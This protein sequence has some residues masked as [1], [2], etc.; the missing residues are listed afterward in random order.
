MGLRNLLSQQ[1]SGGNTLL[2]PGHFVYE[3]G[4]ML[5]E[6]ELSDNT[7][8]SWLCTAHIWAWKAVDS[9]LYLKPKVIFGAEPIETDFT[10]PAV[11]ERLSF[12]YIPQDVFTITSATIALFIRFLSAPP[13]PP[14][15]ATYP[16]TTELPLFTLRRDHAIETL[17]GRAELAPNEFR[18]MEAFEKG[19]QSID[20]SGLMKPKTGLVWKLQYTKKTRRRIQVSVIRLN[21]KFCREGLGL[22]IELLGDEVILKKTTDL[23]NR[24]Q[25]AHKK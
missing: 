15:I 22:T 7:L 1:S 3:P 25:T 24:A 23:L 5:D 21:N 8:D 10:D 20:C 11:R 14:W 12:S 4:Y 9:P 17:S 6:E 19:R 16:P 2:T 18:L 13:S